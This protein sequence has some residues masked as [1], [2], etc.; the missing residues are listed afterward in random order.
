MEPASKRVC[1]GVPCAEKAC[2]AG[3][4]RWTD[5]AKWQSNRSE[6][7]GIGS[8]AIFAIRL[9]PSEHVNT[10][11]RWK[12]ENISWNRT[13]PDLHSSRAGGERLSWRLAAVSARTLLTLPATV[14]R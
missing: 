6:T 10:L 12:P 5:F 2:L 8:P 9:K 3:S 11:T 7:S 1:L 4:G 13:F 14:L